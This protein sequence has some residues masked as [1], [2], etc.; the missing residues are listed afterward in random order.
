MSSS[1]IIPILLHPCLPILIC[2]LILIL[3]VIIGHFDIF[4][5]SFG[6][7]SVPGFFFLLGRIFSPVFVLVLVVLLVVLLV[8]LLGELFKLSLVLFLVGVGK[9]FPRAGEFLVNV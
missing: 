4:V 1:L 7:I 6:L 9:V 8:R 2:I 3:C 5:L